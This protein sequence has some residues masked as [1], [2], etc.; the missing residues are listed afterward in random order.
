[1]NLISKISCK[2]KDGFSLFKLKARNQTIIEKSVKVNFQTDMEDNVKIYRNTKIVNS[3]IGRGTYIGWNSVLNRVKVGRFCS[4]APF[5][6]VIYGRH[7]IDE[8]VSSH[9]AF[10]STAAQSG[11]SFVKESKFD[12][13][14][15]A[16]KSS[17][18]SVVIGNDVWIGY[19]VKIMEGLTI[20]DGAI[21]GAGSLV[22]KN[23][24][25]YGIYVGIPAKKVRL[26]FDS[27]IVEK[28]IEARWWNKDFEWIRK[29]SDLFDSPDKIIKALAE[30]NSEELN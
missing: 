3:F 24:E 21:V 10:Y 5:V 27:E 8:F 13:F 29:N 14:V 4:I 19:G 6:E 22:T 23:V 12:E 30:V 17:N 16:N 15:Y 11:F 18:Y 20:G 9:P 25:A 28:L 7:A 2:V 1:M 26:R